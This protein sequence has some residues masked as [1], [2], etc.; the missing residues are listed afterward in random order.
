MLER[1]ACTATG[2]SSDEVAGLVPWRSVPRASVVT[3][4][5]DPVGGFLAR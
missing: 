4:A 2:A 3:G 5:Y 1:S